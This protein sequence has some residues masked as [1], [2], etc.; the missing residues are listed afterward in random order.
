MS[1]NNVSTNEEG[2]L[3]QIES[4]YKPLNL[5]SDYILKKIF[6]NIQKNKALEI[7]KYNKYIQKRLNININD[8]KEYLDIYSPIEIEIIPAKNKYGQFI[9]ILK[10]QQIYFHIYFNDNKK[11]IFTN[12]L[13]KEFNVKKIK[14]VIDYQIK[15]FK[16]LFFQCECIESIYF[17]KFYRNNID[18]MRAMFGECLSLKE[19]NLSNFNTNNVKNMNN[20]FSDCSLLKELNLSKF[21][22]KN[23]T[24]MSFMFSWCS[25]LEV[26]NLKNF[27][28]ENVTN[29]EFMFTECLSLKELELSN[30]NTENVINM[31]NMFYKCL[32]LKEL[33]ISN[34]N[35]N[36]VKDMTLIFQGCTDDLK[37][38]I[39]AQRNDI[40]ED[41]FE[42]SLFELFNHIVENL[43]L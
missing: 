30:F 3:N 8:Y 27:N 5:K 43:S 26:L 22:T 35:I 19:L 11:E 37:N 41:V 34:F 2:K 10:G 24:D 9:N 23:V 21:N 40:S 16:D 29:M 38:K 18:N 31:S 42:P 33:D 28:T 14:I 25:S 4:N 36:K 13:R 39:R 1:S 6:D 20:M 7:I 17:K 32:S 12:I 15:S